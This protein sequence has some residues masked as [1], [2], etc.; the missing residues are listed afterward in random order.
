M[1]RLT[2]TLPMRWGCEELHYYERP[3]PAEPIIPLSART[4]CVRRQTLSAR[5][6]CVPRGGPGTSIQTLVT[7]NKVVVRKNILY[8]MSLKQTAY[9]LQVSNAV[10]NVIICVENPSTPGATTPPARQQEEGR[11]WTAP[12]KLIRRSPISILYLVMFAHV[13]STTMRTHI[14]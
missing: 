10:L 3:C 7:S 6:S 14:Y 1:R 11:R 2:K 12:V 5:T 8:C 4:W 9:W 13:L